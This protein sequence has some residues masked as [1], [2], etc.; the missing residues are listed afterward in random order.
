MVSEETQL[1]ILKA[2]Y[3]STAPIKFY[4]AASVEEALKT[5][6]TL[7][8]KR[9]E[10]IYYLQ[11]YTQAQPSSKIN[12]SDITVTIIMGQFLC[13]KNMT[14]YPAISNQLNFDLSGEFQKMPR[15]TQ[16]QAV[17]RLMPPYSK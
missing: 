6:V 14:K 3:Q 9:D 11:R 17:L 12:Q 8:A 10:N 2:R 5:C 4:G 1:V 15:N 13:H 16:E 7:Y